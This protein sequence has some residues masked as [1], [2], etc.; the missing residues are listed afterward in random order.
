MPTT[1]TLL[2]YVPNIRFSHLVVVVVVSDTVYVINF[3]QYELAEEQ[4]LYPINNECTDEHVN[5]L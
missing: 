1:G 3:P 2:T 4:L 5:V